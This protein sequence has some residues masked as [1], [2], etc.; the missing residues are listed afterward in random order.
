MKD[1]V[2]HWEFMPPVPADRVFLPSTSTNTT[3]KLFSEN[4]LLKSAFFGQF[5]QIL[6][7]IRLRKRRQQCGKRCG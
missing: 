7:G 6:Q 2:P 3:G 5:S 4:N 1:Q